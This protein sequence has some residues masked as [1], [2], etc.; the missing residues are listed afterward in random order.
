MRPVEKEKHR[1][2]RLVLADTLLLA[3]LRARDGVIPQR[4]NHHGDARTCP[5]ADLYD[6]GFCPWC[7]QAVQH[8]PRAEVRKPHHRA[9][10]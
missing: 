9:A 10:A 4:P 7:R 1:M 3:Q 6:D 8:R 5:Y 2:A